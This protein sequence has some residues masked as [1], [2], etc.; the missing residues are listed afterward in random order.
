MLLY[1]L[2]DIETISKLEEIIHDIGPDILSASGKLDHYCTLL[3]TNHFEGAEKARDQL[4][5]ILDYVE[6]SPQKVFQYAFDEDSLLDALFFNQFAVHLCVSKKAL[7]SSDLGCMTKSFFE[8]ALIVN[9][10]IED[11][12]LSKHMVFLHIVPFLIAAKNYVIE[13]F[14]DKP[15]PDAFERLTE[16]IAVQSLCISLCQLE[17]DDFIGSRLLMTK[18]IRKLKAEFK[19]KV[20]QHKIYILCLIFLGISY[21][22]KN[23]PLKCEKKIKKAQKALKKVTD[24]EDKKEKKQLFEFVDRVWD[25]LFG[26]DDDDDAFYSAKPHYTKQTKRKI[27][28]KT[29]SRKAKVLKQNQTAKASASKAQLKK[30]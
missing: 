15:V 9:E 19:E 22:G 21:W 14:K 13:T 23:L 4:L 27:K 17:A 2:E 18:T 5:K 7:S 8:I 30:K 29:S 1:F 12:V 11:A 16:V 6:K 10:A 20:N 24:Y 3:R 25:K 26:D 28:T